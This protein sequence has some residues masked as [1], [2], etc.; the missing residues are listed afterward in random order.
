[1][2]LASLLVYLVVVVMMVPHWPI[3]PRAEPTERETIKVALVRLLLF[4]FV[5]LF[6][7]CHLVIIR[8]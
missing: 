2:V 7:T 5:C 3:G 4:G 1:M 8:N 6:R